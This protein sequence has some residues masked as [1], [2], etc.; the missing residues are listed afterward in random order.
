MKLYKNAVILAVILAILAGAY[1]LIGR[2]PKKDDAASPNDTPSKFEKIISGDKDNITYILI[3]NKEGK[4]E[5]EKKDKDW[6]ILQPKDINAD[7]TVADRAASNLSALTADKVIEEN[8]TDLSQYGFDKPAVVTVKFKDGSSKVIEIG[9]LTSTRDGYYIKEKSSSKVYVIGTYS[10]DAINIK[11]DDL[12]SKALYT[13]N[14]DE[15]LGMSMSKQGTPFFSGKKNAEGIWE[16]TA[17]IESRMDMAN[18]TPFLEA[19]ASVNVTNFV[20]EKPA[21]L[22]KY[23][24]KTPAFAF[25]IEASGAKHKLML[26][27]EKEKGTEIY[28]MLDN[29]NEVFTI[30]L[31]P[32]KFLDK[33]LKE[34]VES[35]IYITNI[36]DVSKI[37]VEMDGQ[38]VTSD[39]QQDSGG[40]KEKDKFTVNGR[41]ANVKNEKEDSLFRKYYQGIVGITLSDIEAGAV[42]SGKPEVTITYTLKKAP[43][44]VK[45]EL[46]PKNNDYYYAVVNNKYT[47]KIVAKKKLDDPEGIRES[48]KKLKEAMDKQGK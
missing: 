38:T 19:V 27:S 47:G 30:D 1:V 17:P 10:I 31:S 13:V 29:R 5:F 48:Y 4:F 36:D 34:I 9:N 12:K 3:E 46:I 26:G 44:T 24:L 14:A 8:A 23:G 41:D 39:L 21:D 32:F 6:E 16:L 45:V 7:K 42:P 20:E 35:F 33:P 40:D 22:A 2:L 18:F 15:I 37:V 43:G 28:A 11:K 25:E